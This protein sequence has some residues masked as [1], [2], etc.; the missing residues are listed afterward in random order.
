MNGKVSHLGLGISRSPILIIFST[1]GFMF[2]FLTTAGGGFSD[3]D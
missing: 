3:D 1:C 2:L